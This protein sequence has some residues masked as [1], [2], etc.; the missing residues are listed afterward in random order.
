VDGRELY[1][2]DSAVGFANACIKAI[3]HPERAA[4][5]A[6]RAWKLFLEK[7]TWDSIEPHIWAATEECMRLNPRSSFR[8]GST[9]M[10]DE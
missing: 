4:Q 1:L 3:R 8:A 10:S 6:E 2:A 7:W 9:A 5:M